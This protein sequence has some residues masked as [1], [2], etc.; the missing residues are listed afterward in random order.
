[1]IH[2]E[3]DFHHFEKAQ[4]YRRLVEVYFNERM[5]RR[6]RQIELNAKKP[7]SLRTLEGDLG[8]HTRIIR[9]LREH[10]PELTGWNM[11]QEEHILTYLLTLPLRDREVVRK[12]LYA[13]FRLARQRKLV[14]HVPVANSPLGVI[15]HSIQIRRR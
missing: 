6:K 2:L 8:T 9:W 1:M 12:D 10:L 5:E 14:T 15:E 7:L 3:E 13:F 4:E 11:V